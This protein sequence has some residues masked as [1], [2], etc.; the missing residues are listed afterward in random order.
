VAIVVSD[1]SPIRALCHLNL[2]DLLERLY[3]RVYLPEDVADE[4]NHASHRFAAFDPSIYA[5]LIVE[6]PSNSARVAELEQTLDRGEAAA[7]ILAL[8][9]S[10]DYVLMDER[11]GRRVAHQLGLT[12]IGVL[13]VLAEA[14]NRKL[15]PALRPLIERLR[16]E[17]SFHISATLVAEILKN[18]QE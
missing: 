13:G 6:S 2:L 14:K 5:F 1:T 8:E 15:I 9:R 4:L 11:A 10:A 17:L 16:T 3:G 7:I 12:V 18:A